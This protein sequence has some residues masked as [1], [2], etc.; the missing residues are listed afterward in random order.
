MPATRATGQAI[1]GPTGA[2]D[3]GIGFRKS[4][5]AANYVLDTARRNESSRTSVTVHLVER[6]GTVAA[7]W[8]QS[9]T[10]LIVFAA[11]APTSR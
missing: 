5:F 11:A 2:R 10:S 7:G 8:K 6:I 4:G 1:G 3:D 9:Q